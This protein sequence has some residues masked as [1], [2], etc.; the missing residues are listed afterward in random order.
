MQERESARCT[1]NKTLQ[2]SSSWEPHKYT[3]NVNLRRG[4][5]KTDEILRVGRFQVHEHHV[6]CGLAAF[7]FEHNQADLADDFY[8][9]VSAF[10]KVIGAFPSA[11]GADVPMQ[12]SGDC[13]TGRE[14]K[15]AQR[16]L[17]K[18]PRPDRYRGCGRFRR[19]RQ[20]TD[21]AHS[22]RQLRMADGSHDAA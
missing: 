3:R 17:A 18:H 9:R 20:S 5:R 7:H 4:N 2:G 15:A 1:E 14:G 6:K 19:E 10:F 22:S 16:P 21:G 8:A 13:A 11:W 12:S